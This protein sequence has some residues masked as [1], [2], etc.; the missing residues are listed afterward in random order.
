MKPKQKAF[1]LIELLVV[2]AIIGLLAS[3]V[4]IALQSA[5]SKARDANR[6]ATVKE[7][8]T[9]LEL[10]YNDNNGYPSTGNTWAGV[11]SCWGSPDT[12]LTGANG[13][14]PGLAPTYVPSLP[15]D[16]LGDTGCA[17]Q[18]LYNSNGT[19]YFF[20]AYETVENCNNIASDPMH[21]PLSPAD[22]DYAVYSSGAT[23]W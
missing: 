7:I 22:C 21:R 12:A 10:Y 14:I 8:A 15:V 16:P 5:R 6:R 13:Y 20:M 9:A 2:I 19:D 3:I 18:Y 1:T 11:V 17:H 23:N 4:L